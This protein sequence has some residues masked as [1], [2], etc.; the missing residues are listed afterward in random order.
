MMKYNLLCQ[1]I[2]ADHMKRIT[3]PHENQPVTKN[4]DKRHIYTARFLS[5]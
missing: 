4:S 3:Q 2:K 1:I 5:H